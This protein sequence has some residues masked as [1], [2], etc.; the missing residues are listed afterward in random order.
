MQTA[1]PQWRRRRRLGGATLVLAAMMSVA[2][3][4]SH[5]ATHPARVLA[6]DGGSSLNPGETLNPNQALRSPG[7]GYQLAMQA[8]GNLVLSNSGGALWATMTNDSASEHVTMQSD[9]NLVV[10]TGSGAARWNSHTDGFPGSHLGIQDDGNLV[11]VSAGGT[12]VWSSYT[13]DNQRG[14]WLSKSCNAG[15]FAA[16]ILGFPPQ[17]PAGGVGGPTTGPNIDA[18]ARWMR[19]EN[20]PFGCPGGNPLNTTQSEPGS[21]TINGAGVRRYNDANQRT[22][23]FWGIFATDQT[24]L[25][26]R[27]P[28]ILDILRNPLH[29]SH[30]QCV[31]LAQS[32]NM[33][34]WGSTSFHSNPS[35]FCAG[36]P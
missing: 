5:G 35:G 18:I 28:D 13:A 25:N 15:T 20:G 27:Y 33:L 11:I 1:C 14:C 32:P 9:G 19:S 17:A 36:L 22:C 8:D 21:F 4:A 7:G 26:G 3:L 12:P 31:R 6:A 10:Y 29:S 34:T 16:A 23:Q 24:L 2:A 30:D